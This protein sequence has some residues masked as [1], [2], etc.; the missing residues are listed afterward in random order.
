MERSTMLLIGKPSISMGHL[1]HG[2]VSHNQRVSIW[3]GFSITIHFGVHFRKPPS[4]WNPSPHQTKG[5]QPQLVMRRFTSV[6][7]P[8]FR[9]PKWMVLQSCNYPILLPKFHPTWSVVHSFEISFETIWPTIIKHRCLGEARNWDR[10]PGKSQDSVAK[11]P[12][13]LETK[14]RFPW[15]RSSEILMIPS[16]KL[17]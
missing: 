15:T 14:E 2:Y 16:G 11:L 4:A 10:S 5:S 6:Q 9:P 13:G 8:I 3:I 7:Y 1:Y 12:I 17:T